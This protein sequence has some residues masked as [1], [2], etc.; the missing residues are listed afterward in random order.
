MIIGQNLNSLEGLS[1][2]SQND[3]ITVLSHEFYHDGN[4][5]A[6]VDIPKSF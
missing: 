3:M 2:N 5:L 1:V 4:I 6:Q